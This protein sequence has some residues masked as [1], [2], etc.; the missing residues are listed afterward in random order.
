VM[1]VVEYSP[2]PDAFPLQRKFRS[3]MEK[4]RIGVFL[5]ELLV[6]KTMGLIRGR[7]FMLYP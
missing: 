1:Q 6:T 4:K 3:E 7:L 5:Y 2:P